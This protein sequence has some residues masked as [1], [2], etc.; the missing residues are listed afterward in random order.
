MAFTPNPDIRSADEVIVPSLQEFGWGNPS[1]SLKDNMLQEQFHKDQL[2]N[3]MPHV[4]TMGDQLEPLPLLMEAWNA[5]QK[6]KGRYPDSADW[7]LLD[8]FAL[9]LQLRWLP[10]LIGSCCLSN[11]FRGWV[12]RLTYQI[13]LLGEP[14]QYLGKNEFGSSNF[15]P[16]APY[17]YGAARKR[18]KMRGG[19]GLYCSA[20]QES[21]IKDQVIAC[22]TPKL[23]EILAKL[24]ANSDKDF[25]EPQ[26]ESVYRSFGDWNYIEDLRLYADYGLDE[27]PD[28]TSAEQLD[29]AMTLCKPTIQC[30]GI[31]IR[32][33]GEHKD[34]FAIHGLDPSNTWSHNMCHHGRLVASDGD[35]FFRLSNESWPNNPVYNIPFDEV[36]R[37]FKKD[38]LSCG[39]IGRIRGPK[40]SPPT[41]PVPN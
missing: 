24:R 3:E 37:W 28:I 27:C 39:S 8:E 38:L 18:A 31:A 35:R 5:F 13:A 25:P 20:V 7:T 9:N 32:K 17:N 1:W 36:N 16:Y 29:D 19:D 2:Y 26:S 12:V 10:Q 33:I 41:A 40:S 15:A 21:L 4:F 34:G 14:M 11:T 23:L 6:S 30:S 22:N